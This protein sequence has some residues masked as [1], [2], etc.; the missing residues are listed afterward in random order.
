MMFL[1]GMGKEASGMKPVNKLFDSSICMIRANTWGF[2]MLQINK[3]W[4][5]YATD[6]AFW[7]VHVG[8]FHSLSKP[9]LQKCV[10]PW[11][12]RTRMD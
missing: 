2:K 9:C 5:K 12:I 11:W 1:D 3:K 8:S 4:A 10:P 6:N 7:Q